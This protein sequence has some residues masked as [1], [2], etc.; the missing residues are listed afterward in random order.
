M[1]FES[2]S[3]SE[4]A[5]AARLG[6]LLVLMEPPAPLE[7]EFND[8]YD[9]EHLPQRCALPG[10]LDGSRWTCVEGWP[11]WGAFYDLASVDAVDTPEYRA[12][13]G[14]NG[15]PWSRRILPRTIGRTRVVAKALPG[16]ED[17][18]SVPAQASRLMLTRYA[19]RGQQDEGQTMA[20]LGRSKLMEIGAMQ[21]RAFMQEHA[22]EEAKIWLIAAFDQP[23][24]GETASSVAG[25]L[26]GVGA[27]LLNIYVPYRRS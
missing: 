16:S 26:T 6:I 20:N 17:L 13:S 24:S 11:R 22:P 25:R 21:V 27:D 15:T 1:A 23:I 10:F 12:V 4:T 18:G 5:V 14:R 9:T 19:L 3:P 7:E 8:W 2:A